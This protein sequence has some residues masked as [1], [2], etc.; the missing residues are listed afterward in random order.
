[1]QRPGTAGG[2]QAPSPQTLPRPTTAAQFPPSPPPEPEEADLEEVEELS[3]EEVDAEEVL[4]EVQQAEAY[5]GQGGHEDQGGYADPNAGYAETDGY[6]DANSYGEAAV[7]EELEAAPDTTEQIHKVLADANAF[8]RVRL[9]NKALDTLRGGLEIDPRSMDIHEVYRDILIESG[10]TEDAVQEM[11]VIAALYIDSLDG[12]SAA[13]ALQDVLA[14]DP[15]NARA[16]EMLQELGYEIVD[17]NEPLDAGSAGTTELEGGEASYEEAALGEHHEPL[18]SYDLEEMQPTLS[19][20]TT[21]TCVKCSSEARDGRRR[22]RRDRRT[23][24]RAS[25]STNPT[26]TCR[27]RMRTRRTSKGSTIRCSRAG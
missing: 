2:F 18:P 4:D 10:Q 22:R 15:Q 27:T 23:S 25:R 20:R 6:G 17:E 13:R 12:D 5:E 26:R 8:R 3:Y 1:M 16:I 19:R 9:Y 11:L 7:G 21:R 14:F 24:S